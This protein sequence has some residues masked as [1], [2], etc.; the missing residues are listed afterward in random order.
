MAAVG[1]TPS[2]VVAEAVMVDLAC[3]RPILD[4]PSVGVQVTVAVSYLIAPS[5]QVYAS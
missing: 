5:R 3:R 4:V 1:K 2:A